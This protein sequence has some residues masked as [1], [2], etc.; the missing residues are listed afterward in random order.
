MPKSG[1]ITSICR[2]C[3]GETNHKIL[4]SKYQKNLLFEGE[5]DHAPVYEHYYYM[6]VS[7][8]GCEEIS[9]LQRITAD[10]WIDEQGNDVII[11]TSYPSDHAP[12]NFLRSDEE[13]QLPAM[14]RDLYE[15]IKTAFIH[16]SCISAGMCLRALIEALC[17]NQKIEGK[18]L[19]QKIKNLQQ[20]G[21]I[22]LAELPIIDKLRLIGN[23]SA[24]QIKAFPI[25]TL[26]YA[27]DIVNH[28][29]RSVYVLP[30]INKKLKI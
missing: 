11:T 19:E 28:L 9:F 6:V 27:L 29:L 24:H 14:L 25:D 22:T 17:I 18:N 8:A 7:C 4:Y 15:E 2:T 23:V 20:A 1:A 13:D 26:E 30:K 12:F 16:H 10:H 5:E 3:K 21:F